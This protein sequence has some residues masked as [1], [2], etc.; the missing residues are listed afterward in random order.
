[1]AA[2]AR[3]TAK[4]VFPSRFVGR[5]NELG[6]LNGGS[7]MNLGAMAGMLLQTEEGPGSLVSDQALG[8]IVA[9][10]FFIGI[11]WLVKRAIGRKAP[12]LKMSIR[13]ADDSSERAQH[14]LGQR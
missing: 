7:V 9:I 5:K 1:M 6:R 4:T 11:V 3:P 10:M 14:I 13:L 2:H 8:V 12:N